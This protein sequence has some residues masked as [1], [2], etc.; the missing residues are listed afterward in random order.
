VQ[1]LQGYVNAT[2]TGGVKRAS[3]MILSKAF[4]GRADYAAVDF[5]AAVRS[6]QNRQLDAADPGLHEIGY[7]VK[8][9][10]QTHALQLLRREDFYLDDQIQLGGVSTPLANGI[11]VFKIECL[12]PASAPGQTQEVWAEEWN[13]TTQPKDA[14]LPSALRITLGIAGKNGRHLKETVEINLL[15]ALGLK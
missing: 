10:F 11:E 15:G 6:R 9:D 1:Y 2:P 13:S 12:L 14:E 3:G 8:E 4:A 5:H 7:S